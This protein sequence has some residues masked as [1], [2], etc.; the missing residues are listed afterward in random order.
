MKDMTFEKA[1]EKLEKIV[2]QLEG[3][4]LPLEDS[5]K[6][7]E[8]GIKLART[9]QQKLEKAKARIEVLMKDSKG[10]FTRKELDAE[11]EE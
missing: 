8:E 7:Y 1:L 11:E 5:L 4:D 2:D 9:C 3:G 10:K 6:R